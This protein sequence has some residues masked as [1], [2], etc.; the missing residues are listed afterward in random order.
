M[1]T[2]FSIVLVL[3]VLAATFWAGST[4]TLARSDSSS[5]G[6][7]F[8]PQM[9]AAAATVLAGAYV[10]AKMF[11]DTPGHAVVGIGALAALAAIAVQGVLV[12]LVR[13]RIA[14]DPS[15]RARATLGHRIASGLLALTIV[16]MVIQ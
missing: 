1:A 4:F 7:L 9:G 6:Q 10:W 5:T 3:H 14:T 8:V 11:S 15:A 16:C 13:R 12:G 2:L